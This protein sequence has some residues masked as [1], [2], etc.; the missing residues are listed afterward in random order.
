MG[1]G[2]VLSFERFG[3]MGSHVVKEYVMFRTL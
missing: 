3:E 1:V 2:L